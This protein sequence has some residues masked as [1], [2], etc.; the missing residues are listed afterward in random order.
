[1]AF[2]KRR[3]AYD[4]PYKLTCNVSK[5]VEFRTAWGP[6]DPD[7]ARFSVYWGA[8]VLGDADNC[9]LRDSPEFLAQYP[10]FK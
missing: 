7:S 2:R 8:N 4:T 3:S 5:T 9:A 6:G 1:M 10:R